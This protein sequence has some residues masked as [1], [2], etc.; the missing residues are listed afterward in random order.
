MRRIEI[1]TGDKLT[2]EAWRLAFSAPRGV[3]YNDSQLPVNVCGTFYVKDMSLHPELPYTIKVT[4]FEDDCEVIMTYT[5]VQLLESDVRGEFPFM[6]TEFVQQIKPIGRKAM[7]DFLGDN[8]THIIAE[9]AAV[10]AA[11]H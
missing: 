10:H 11:C 5:G 9:E 6:A 8:I 3:L 7:Q 4:V 1:F 2:A